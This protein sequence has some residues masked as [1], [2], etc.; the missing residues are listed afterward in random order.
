MIELSGG[1]QRN[2]VQADP[3]VLVQVWGSGDTEVTKVNPWE[4]TQQVWSALARTDEVDIDK[5]EVMRVDLTLPVY[6][7]DEA[8]G[9]PRY[10]FVYAPTV[11]LNTMEDLS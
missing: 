9:T 6:Y 7:P 4:L 5:V 8:T 10:T 11:N 3:T 2:L 1:P